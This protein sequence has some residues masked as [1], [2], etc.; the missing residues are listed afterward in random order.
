[1]K[2]CP[3][4]FCMLEPTYSHAT[5]VL[6]ASDPGRRLLWPRER[7]CFYLRVRSY[8]VHKERA[9]SVTPLP[10]PPGGPFIRRR[11]AKKKEI[12]DFCLPPPP[13]PRPSSPALE[14]ESAK[15]FSFLRRFYLRKK[16]LG[17]LEQKTPHFFSR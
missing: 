5:H 15:M 14:N 4:L 1:M 12:A 11:K 7:N 6:I 10:P 8:T 3:S 17:G 9:H 2:S 13:Y 16:N